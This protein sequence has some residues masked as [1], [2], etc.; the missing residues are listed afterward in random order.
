MRVASNAEHITHGFSPKDGFLASSM[1]PDIFLRNK[2]C[3]FF[4]SIFL[5]LSPCG[6]LHWA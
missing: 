1:S 2:L 6:A 5:S 3:M 4:S